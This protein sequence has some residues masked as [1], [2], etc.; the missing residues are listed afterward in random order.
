[1][2]EFTPAG[3]NELLTTIKNAGYLF[4]SFEE[5]EA[6]LAE[7]RPFVV[8]RHDIDIHLRPAL[9]IARIEYEQGVSATYFVLLRS[10][11]YNLF[12]RASAEM[13]DQ[14]HQLGHELAA[15]LDLS[16]YQNDCARALMEVE[17]LAKFYPYINPRLVT[18]HSP[19]DLQRLPV[20]AFPQLAAVYA[21]AM[22]GEIAYLSDSTGR[23]RYGHPLDS[24]AFQSRKPF[25][26][27]THPVW[28]VQEGETP[29]QKLKAWLYEDY[30]SCQDELAAFLPKL[31]QLD[32]V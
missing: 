13:M 32:H 31:F 7:G 9:D 24:E 19:Y 27:L 4:C 22:R 21:A 6:K 29:A 12:S 17:V 8:L 28:W 10:P 11:F 26:L 1:M 16:V 2:R 23:W 3:Y 14:I 20:A 30:L 18:I 5:V 15:H 25:Q